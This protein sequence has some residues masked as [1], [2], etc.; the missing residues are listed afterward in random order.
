MSSG[1]MVVDQGNV[2]CYLQITP[3]LANMPNIENA[4]SAT[5]TLLKEKASSSHCHLYSPKVCSISRI[6]RVVLMTA[7]GLREMLS[8]PCSTRNCANSG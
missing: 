2:I 7:S 1:V 8:M 6:L 3:D 5:R 4:F